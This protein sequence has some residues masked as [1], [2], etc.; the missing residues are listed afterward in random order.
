MAFYRPFLRHSADGHLTTNPHKVTI[1]AMVVMN[2]K[3]P[4][5]VYRV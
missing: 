4:G 1:R 5:G 3:G 2:I